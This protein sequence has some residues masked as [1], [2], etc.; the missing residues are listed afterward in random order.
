VSIQKKSLIS[1]LKTAKKAN[2]A[3]AHDV[4]GKSAKVSSMRH[5]SSK[6]MVSNKMVSNKM[7]SNKQVSAKKLLSA[8]H[9]SA[10]SVSSTRAIS[11]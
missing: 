11:Q 5:L 8:K 3:A 9:A 1:T 6:K 2:V 4:D 7:V 10:R